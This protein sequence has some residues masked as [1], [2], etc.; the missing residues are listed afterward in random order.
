M[1]TVPQRAVVNK[2]EI[3]IRTLLDM[4][5]GLSDQA[6]AIIQKQKD[7][8]QKYYTN[9]IRQLRSENED[10]KKTLAINKNILSQVL[11]GNQND[12][13]KTIEDSVYT[14]QE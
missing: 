12:I 9:E 4:P 6:N 14:M 13:L 10:L 1:S 5:S 3:D 11:S 2:D 7:L 8:K